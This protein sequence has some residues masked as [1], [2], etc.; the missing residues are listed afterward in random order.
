MENENTTTCMYM[1]EKEM[2]EEIRIHISEVFDNSMEDNTENEKIKTFFQE[3]CGCTLGHENVSCSETINKQAVE[4]LRVCLQ[5]V[6]SSEKDIAILSYFVMNHPITSFKRK[7]SPY[8]T[9]R[10]FGN[11]VCK[12]MFLFA[13]DTS[14]KRFHTISYHYQ[15]Y[16]LTPR[17]H[18]NTKRVPKNTIDIET[19]TYVR[20]FIEN[21]V[22]EN[23]I[24]PSCFL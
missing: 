3:N 5:E 17:T 20:S 18:G 8:S 23:F 7:R 13:Y 22:E 6:V 12:K 11:V 10:L 24:I 19:T 21:Y 16:G 1:E 15:N 4:H 2:E 9:F 14:N